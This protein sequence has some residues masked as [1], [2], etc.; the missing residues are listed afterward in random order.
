MRNL[1]VILDDLRSEIE[2]IDTAHPGLHRRLTTKIKDQIEV[3]EELHRR[4]FGE[5]KHRPDVELITDLDDGS[6]MGTVCLKCGQKIECFWS[7]DD[8]R[9][10]RWSDWSYVVWR[11]TETGSVARFYGCSINDPKETTDGN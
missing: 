4:A 10:P 8:D 11:E 9:A 2:R 5:G 6:R 7:V 1:Q 3:L